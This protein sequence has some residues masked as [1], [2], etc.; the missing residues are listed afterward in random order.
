MYLYNKSTI[1]TFDYTKDDIYSKIQVDVSS[2]SIIVIIMLYLDNAKIGRY[3]NGKYNYY[4]ES[5]KNVIDNMINEIL[6]MLN[7]MNY[8]TM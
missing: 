3:Y 8:V 2:S 7:D 1:Y 6:T 5:Y 4:D